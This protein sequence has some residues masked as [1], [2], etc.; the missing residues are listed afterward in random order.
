MPRPVQPGCLYQRADDNDHRQ[1]TVQELHRHG[2]VQR[3]QWSPGL[4]AG[5]RPPIVFYAKKVKVPQWSPGLMA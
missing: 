1:P 4:M 3:P 2:A 5:G